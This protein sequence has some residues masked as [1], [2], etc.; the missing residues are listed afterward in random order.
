[1]R[2]ALDARP[3]FSPQ[4]RGIGKS[5]LALYQ[6]VAYLRPYWEV[7]A[8]H[9]LPGQ[10][11]PP[12]VAQHFHPRFMEM[13][14]DR[15]NAWEGFRLP[16]TAW[17]HG[18]DMLH[19]PANSCPRWPMVP[20]LVTVHDI[21]P[22]DEPQYYPAE[23][24]QRFEKGVRTACQNGWIMCPS[25]FTKQRLMERFSADAQRIIVNPWASGTG[26]KLVEPARA[27]KVMNRYGIAPPYVIHLGA[28]DPRKNT[29]HVID[30]WAMLEKAARSSWELV[31]VGLSDQTRSE[32]MTIVERL[33]LEANVH[34]L[35]YVKEEELSC[36]MTGAEVLAYPS[37]SEGFGLP[38]LDAFATDTAVLAANATSVPEV[39]GDAAVLVDPVDSCAVARGLM[40]LMRD[41]RLREQLVEKGRARLEQYTWQATAARFVQTVERMQAGVQSRKA[42]VAA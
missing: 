35:G 5:L 20:T 2:I 12:I 23:Q 29:R 27:Q 18:V 25:E 3:I 16:L 26:I 41:K 40:K 24:V 37:L 39:T 28:A 9:R 13:P 32:L 7:Y 4:R 19:C 21:I 34:L 38:V 42:Q 11:T 33:S 15:W 36:L 30:A 22:L 6:H 8:Y 17:T 10:V 31:I 1:M 14:G